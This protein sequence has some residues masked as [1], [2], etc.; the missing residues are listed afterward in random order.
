M[1]TSII[2][3]SLKGEFGRIAEK[4]GR[5]ERITAEEG[6]W[7]YENAET[8]ALGMLATSVK[9][10]LTS[11]RVYFNRNFHIE[12]T[13]ICIHN[14]LFCSYRRRIND[15]EA[16]EYSLEEITELA[17][18]H[19]D[20]NVT[21]VHIV[22]GVHPS[23]DLEYYCTLIR[24]V[25][26]ELPGVQVKAYTAVE[27]DHM[28]HKAGLSI[29]EGLKKLREAGLDSIPGGG[30]EIFDE[31]LRK[32]IAPDKT[33]SEKWLKIHETAHELKIP[34][35]ATMLYG[36]LEEYKHRIDHLGRLRDLQDKTRGFNCFIPLKY[37]KSGNQMSGKPETTQVEDM[38]NYAVSRI[39]LDNI[40]HLKAYWPMIGRDMAEL[41]LSFGVDDLD[42]TIEDTTRIYSMAGSREQNPSMTAD[43][44][45]SLI[46][47]N[48]LTAVERDS[49]YKTLKIYKPL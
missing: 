42:G 13:N 18:S 39:F 20:E 48:G 30:A 46:H 41:S 24:A 2:S 11:D 34:T 37:H 9:Q 36:H 15:S 28:S 6:L 10:K 19:R 27:I 40:P 44:L 4:I 35:N 33:S 49:L 17:A 43:E 26:K 7:L 25:K 45:I 23:R 12:P 8:A 47:K 21:E 22:G 31:E 5:S 16:W 3:A 29:Q 14:C 1:Q 32:S 38:R